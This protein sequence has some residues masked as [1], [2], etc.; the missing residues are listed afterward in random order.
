MQGALASITAAVLGVILNLAVWFAIHVLFSNVDSWR[1]GPVQ[2]AVPVPATLELRTLGL[3]VA[4]GVML[5]L[6]RWS[7]HRTLLVTA[8]GALLVEFLAR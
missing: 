4:S 5:L 6:L 7:V 1:A 3:A 2:L 8:A